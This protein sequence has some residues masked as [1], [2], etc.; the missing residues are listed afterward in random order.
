MTLT[1]RDLLAGAA[2]GAGLTGTPDWLH[3]APARPD[4]DGGGSSAPKVLRYAFPAAETGF[5]PVQLSDVY[6][7][8]ITAHVFESPLDY[9]PLARPFLI[10]PGT[11]LA[12]PEIAD[13]HR[14][15]TLKLRPGILFHDDPAFKGRAR[16]LVAEDYIYTIKRFYDPATKSPGHSSLEEQGIIGLRELR[17]AALKSKQ[18]FD[19]DRPVEGL[20]AIDRHTLRIRLREPRP[21]FLYTLT[22]LP[23]MAREVV[24]AY[25]DR[26]MEHPI[27]TGPF[28]LAEWRRSS[29]IV[30]ERFTG[31]RDLRYDAQPN[32]D[33][34]EGQAL[35]ARFKGRRLPMI[36]RVEIAIIE[37]AQ[38]R[39]LA[40]LNGE[41]DLLERV[42]ADYIPQA[43][44]KGELA[45]HLA[46]KGIRHSR[47][48]ASDVTLTVF[49]MEDP[50]VGGLTPEQVALRRAICLGLDIP[51]EIRLG[52][53]GEAIPAQAGITPGTYGFDPLLRTEQG[54][55]D[56][57]RAR[58]L[59]DTWGWRDRD[60]DGWRERP[61]GTKLTLVMLSQSDQTSR[62]LDEIYKKN[63]DAL[64]LRVE[65]K[66]GQWSEN[67]KSTRSGKFMMWRVGSSAG[68][69]D[70]QG[71]LERGHSASVG[72]GNLARFVLPA[73]DRAYDRLTA[74]P[75]GPER[76]EA[77]REANRLMLAYAPYR[78]H[79]HRMVTDLMHRQVVGYRRPPFWLN[80]WST[81]DIEA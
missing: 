32:P 20:T 11:A 31:Y 1:R 64:G 35:L 65:L 4:G 25:G 55:F 66:V 48:A 50:V 70:G 43:L 54:R 68:S 78:Y 52:R 79:V 40:F 15:F 62:Q 33:D 72:K 12:L 63:M 9:D 24:E 17:E 81:V 10:R 13:D 67:L 8:T 56:P 46:R 57:A 27:G 6:S 45:P 69:P 16:E 74:L 18:P 44:V 53:R 51:R 37:E 29:R 38:P 26:I 21:R 71:A 5:D 80:W 49:N 41:Q 60:G 14:S 42:P 2:A 61:D 73:F 36:D 7:L 77:F 28:R 39:W 34:A 30:M 58:A 23:A 19:Y 59:L 76:L 3:A 22:G 47:V 75:D